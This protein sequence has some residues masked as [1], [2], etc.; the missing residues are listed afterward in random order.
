MRII[1][2]DSITSRRSIVAIS[3]IVVRGLLMAILSNPRICPEALSESVIVNRH[4]GSFVSRFTLPFGLE[5][6]LK[7]IERKLGFERIYRLFQLIL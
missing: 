2:A 7:V 3:G 6:S 5:V 4:W 1:R